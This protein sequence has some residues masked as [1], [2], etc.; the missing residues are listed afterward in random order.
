MILNRNNIIAEK[1]DGQFIPVTA[2]DT[3]EYYGEVTAVILCE[4]DAIGSVILL[5]RDPKYKMG[6]LEQK[7]ALTAAG[8]LGRQMES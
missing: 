5:S 3:E 8:F 4:G 6:T 1:N 7:L 2:E